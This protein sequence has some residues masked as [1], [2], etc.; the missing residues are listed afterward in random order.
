MA[1]QRDVRKAPQFILIFRR[2]RHH[3]CFVVLSPHPLLTSSR[4]TLVV[5]ISLI[6]TMVISAINPSATIIITASTKYQH[7][8]HHPHQT[9]H[10]CHQT[11]SSSE[12]IADVR[13]YC[14]R[15]TPSPTSDTIAIVR[16]HRRHHSYTILVPSA[17]T[18]VL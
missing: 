14:R 3:G 2:F 12:T 6:L 4:T 7:H 9:Q 1:L 15:Q 17:T 8:H 13:H 10:R 5:T 16:Q 18:A 11:P